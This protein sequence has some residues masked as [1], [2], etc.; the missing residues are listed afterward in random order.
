MGS[1]NETLTILLLSFFSFFITWNENACC[2]AFIMNPTTRLDCYCGLEYLVTIALS[3]R[4]HF[5]S[6]RIKGLLYEFYNSSMR[7]ILF[8]IPLNCWYC[9]HTFDILH[10]KLKAIW[11]TQIQFDTTF[12]FTRLIL[13]FYTNSHGDLNKCFI[14]QQ[15][16]GNVPRM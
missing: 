15:Q 12:L 2:R 9:F 16:G 8:F 10:A 6:R 5:I 7:N 11:Q 1:E 13:M 3:Y 14:F 4:K